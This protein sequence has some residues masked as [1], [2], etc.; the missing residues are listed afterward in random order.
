MNLNVG[1]FT[2][3]CSY[4]MCNSK[5]LTL[6][7]T[8]YRYTSFLRYIFL[9]LCLPFSFVFT[10]IQT[11]TL[12]QRDTLTLHVQMWFSPGYSILGEAQEELSSP[13]QKKLLCN[14]CVLEERDRCEKDIS[15]RRR[16]LSVMFSLSNLHFP[17]VS[18]AVFSHVSHCRLVG[19]IYD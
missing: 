12:A 17:A 19:R 14:I 16:C 5:V 13:S 9:S 18:Y 4:Y 1:I 2:W 6:F 10:H 15:H 3:E 11:Q 7:L 8:L